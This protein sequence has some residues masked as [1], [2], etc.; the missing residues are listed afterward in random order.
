VPTSPPPSP[1][2]TSPPRIGLQRIGEGFA[3][4]LVLAVPGDGSGRLFIADQVGQIWI[5]DASG[6]RQ[7]QPFLDLRDRMVSLN[8][9]YDERG[10]LGLAFHPGFAQ[11]GRFYVY[12]SAPLRQG[13]PQD[14]NHTSHISEFQVSASDA[15]RADPASERIV[16]EVDEP[17]INHN[18]GEL[19]FGP[20]GY[21]Y[22]SLGDGGAANDTGLGHPPQGNGQDTSTLLGSILRID[23][24]SSQPYSIPADNP[25]AGGGGRGEIWAYGLRNPFR[26]SFDTGGDHQLFAGDVGQNLFEEVD[27][28]V[29]GGNYGW[30]IREGDH[31][32]DP[33]RPSS[34]PARCPDIGA[35]GQALLPPILEF[36][37]DVGIAVT[38]GYVYRGSQMPGL[39]GH[40]LFGAWTESFGAGTGTL[41]DG[42]PPATRSGSWTMRTFEI[43]TT[44]NGKL[45]AYL[46]AFG[47]DAAGELYV[48]T[49]ERAG[50][51]GSTG[52]VSRIVP[53]R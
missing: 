9:S 15:N 47:Q 5:L 31:C 12:Y 7:S 28:V 42:V 24:D 50:P 27:V 13:A 14:W 19:A 4:P 43:A 44:G 22:I 51:A 49:S 25:F 17:E 32:F 38:G 18:G 3:A 23:A 30:N 53:A 20:D 8:A 35:N 45:G 29:K 1:T 11:N 36:E 52:A 40:Y 21:L 26:F 2:P 41:L 33:Q 39:V 34:P 6:N 46:L 37:H 48:L 10:L 16:L